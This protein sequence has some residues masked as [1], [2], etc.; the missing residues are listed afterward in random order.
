[1]KVTV[2]FELHPNADSG[3][4]CNVLEEVIK[5]QD[6][7]NKAIKVLY[8]DEDWSE[9]WNWIIIRELE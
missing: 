4:I 2:V 7:D 3:D 8:D 6:P 1:M 5:H 9:H